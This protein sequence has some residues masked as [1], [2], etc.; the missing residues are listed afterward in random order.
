M[1]CAPVHAPEGDEA[2]EAEVLGGIP[3]ALAELNTSIVVIGVA[4]ARFSVRVKW[5]AVTATHRWWAS[6]FW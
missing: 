1:L 5:F 2:A 3:H 4:V 6:P